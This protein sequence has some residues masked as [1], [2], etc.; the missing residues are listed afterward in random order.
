M[1]SSKAMA[2]LREYLR[3]IYDGDYKAFFRSLADMADSFARDR[4]LAP[5]VKY[6]IREMRVRAY[7][8]FL[9]AYRSVELG[10]MSAAFGVSPAF[11]DRELS[12]FIAVSGFVVKR[13]G[14]G[15]REETRG[16]EGRRDG[17]WCGREEETAGET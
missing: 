7:S 12:R 8:Q 6:I 17:G 11:M 5:H 2:P 13:G 15:W 1:L 16:G 14:T 3:S 9:A 4:M 10:N